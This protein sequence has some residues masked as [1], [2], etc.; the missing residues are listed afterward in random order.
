MR[1]VL[2]RAYNEK[3][4]HISLKINNCSRGN[5]YVLEV[6]LISPH[7]SVIPA[8]TFKQYRIKTVI[9]YVTLM[10]NLSLPIPRAGRQL[11]A[12]NQSVSSRSSPG[13]IGVLFRGE[14]LIKAMPY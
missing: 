5:C 8:V 7:H 10:T 3:R 13:L 14:V 11:R 9:I 6:A 12:R 1:D 4:R 2:L